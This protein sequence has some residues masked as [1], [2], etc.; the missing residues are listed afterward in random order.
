MTDPIDPSDDLRKRIAEI[1]AQNDELAELQRVT[2]VTQ[3]E[4]I[5]NQERRAQAAELREQAR[6]ALFEKDNAPEGR[7]KW[8]RHQLAMTAMNGMIFDQ[9]LADAA[10][11]ALVREAFRVADRMLLLEPVSGVPAVERAE[12]TSDEDPDPDPPET[13]RSGQPIGDIDT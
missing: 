7:R 5:K 8:Q 10:L 13:P 1:T 11:N 6:F 9:P 12:L 3:L 2:F 4:H